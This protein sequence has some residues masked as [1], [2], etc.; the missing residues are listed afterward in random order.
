MDYATSLVGAPY[1]WWTDRS[2][3]LGE[4]A[5]AWAANGPPP[6]RQQVMNN[7]IFCAGVASVM[8]RVVGKGHETPRNYPY[9]GGTRAYYNKYV[10]VSERFSPNKNYPEGT[11]FIRNDKQN[12]DGSTADQGHVAVM[13]KNGKVL[14]SYPGAGVSNS[15]SLR[16]S[17]ATWNGSNY[18]EIAVLPQNWL[19]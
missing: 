6:S 8:L 18:Y 10:G 5:P 3:P 1:A 7:G 16:D 17:K 19:G 12:W 13:A 15:V 9:D 2:G 14:Q 4:G 11:L